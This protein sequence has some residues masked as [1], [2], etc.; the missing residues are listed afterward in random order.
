MWNTAFT[1]SGAHRSRVIVH[2][3][4]RGSWHRDRGFGG[5]KSVRDPV[6][7]RIRGRIFKLDRAGLVGERSGDYVKLES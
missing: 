5:S 2:L 4:E 6:A 1:G 7:G 3:I